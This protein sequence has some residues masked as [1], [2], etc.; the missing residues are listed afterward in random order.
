MSVRLRRVAI[1]L[2]FLLAGCSP[3]PVVVKGRLLKDGSPM[4][5]SEDTY[6]TISF[7]PETPPADGAKSYTAKFDQKTGN[8]TVELPRGKYR[9]MVVIALPSKKQGKLN[10]PTPPVKSDQVYDLS[11]NQDLDLEVPGK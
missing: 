11:K 7:V 3:S 1:G 10:M 2:A 4:A 5:V 9:T 6:V 8:Y